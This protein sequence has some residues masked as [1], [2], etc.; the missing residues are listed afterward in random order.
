MLQ[1]FDE[2][3][4]QDIKGIYYKQ[5]MKISLVLWLKENIVL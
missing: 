3:T 2:V 1:L 5:F 4:K